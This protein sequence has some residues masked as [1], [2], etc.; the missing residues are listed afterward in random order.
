MFGIV[1][2]VLI[3]YFIVKQ[4][5]QRRQKEELGRSES[6]KRLSHSIHVRQASMENILS[7]IEPGNEAQM[8]DELNERSNKPDMYDHMK[9]DEMTSP[10]LY[11]FDK[12][13]KGGHQ[14]I[15]TGS[16]TYDTMDTIYA[17]QDG[18]Y[19]TMTDLQRAADPTPPTLTDINMYDTLGGKHSALD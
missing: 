18:C 14:A 11:P 5:Q 9:G 3:H 15:Q 19:S 16:G 8:Y 17:L 12:L 7:V 13:D 10:D 4:R 1:A 6:L 2:F